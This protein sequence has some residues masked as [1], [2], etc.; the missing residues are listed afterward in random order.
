I[1]REVVHAADAIEEFVEG[2]VEV[3]GDRVVRIGGDTVDE[4]V[5][6]THGPLTGAVEL[7]APDEDALV[8]EED[9]GGVE[10][11]AVVEGGALAQLEGPCEPIRGGGPGER[12]AGFQLQRAALVAKQ[13]LE[14][15]CVDHRSGAGQLLPGIEVFDLAAEVDD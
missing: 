12:Q 10:G 1:R 15:L 2:P 6:P 9:G 13:P 4:G 3:E 5:V 14:D 8:V 7:A 11:G